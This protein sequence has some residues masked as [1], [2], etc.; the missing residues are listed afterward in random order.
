MNRYKLIIEDNEMVEDPNA[1]NWCLYYNHLKEV[2]HLKEAIKKLKHERKCLK[3][4]ISKY[5]KQVE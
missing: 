1:G 4:A 2:Q 5:E 3:I